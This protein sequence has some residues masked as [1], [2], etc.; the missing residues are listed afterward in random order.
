LSWHAL[1]VFGKRNE[2]SSAQRIAVSNRADL[3][4]PLN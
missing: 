1:Q 3:M 4:Q 2:I